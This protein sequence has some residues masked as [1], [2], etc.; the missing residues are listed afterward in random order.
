MSQMAET[1][2]PAGERAF[3]A[4]GPLPIA[5]ASAIRGRVRLRTLTNLRWM[6]SGGQTV[7]LFLV[8][9]GFKYPLPIVQCL[10]CVLIAATAQGGLPTPEL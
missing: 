5:S 2:P 3:A 10:A 7:A 4:P 6:A 9:F 1:T 8:Y